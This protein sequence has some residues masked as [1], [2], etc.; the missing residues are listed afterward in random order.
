MFQILHQ[1]NLVWD[2]ARQIIIAK[3]AFFF[4]QQ[5]KKKNLLLFYSGFGRGVVCSLKMI[6]T[7]N[8]IKSERF[9]IYISAE[10]ERRDNREKDKS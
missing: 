8:K 3:I 2:G 10:I 1:E 5:K 9:D 6:S 7:K 4:F